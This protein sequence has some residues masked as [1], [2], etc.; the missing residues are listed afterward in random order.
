VKAPKIYFRD[1]GLLHALL[2]IRSE[3]DLLRH[4]RLGAS[5]EGFALEHV[6]RLTRPDQAYFWATH[7]G[8]ELDLLMF[9][10]GKRVGVEFKRA[11]APELTRSMSIAMHDLK[12]DA[13]YVVYPGNRRYPLAERIEAVPLAEFVGA[14]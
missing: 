13:L 5:W 8:A 7:T 12:L 3:A 2:G 1:S 14:P 11:D 9:R 4:P 6:L 10:Y